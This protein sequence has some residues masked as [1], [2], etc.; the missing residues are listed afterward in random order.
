MPL[1]AAISGGNHRLQDRLAGYIAQLLGPERREAGDTG[2]QLEPQ[3]AGFRMVPAPSHLAA[4]R[5]CRSDRYEAEPA[6]NCC[7]V[8]L[9][10]LKHGGTC[11]HAHTVV[12]LRF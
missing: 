1:F 10:A 4:L 9:P 5:V 3:D 8:L 12:F 7:A 6:S 2:A 11:R